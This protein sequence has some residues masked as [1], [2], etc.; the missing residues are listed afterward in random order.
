MA[1]EQQEAELTINEAELT[2]GQVRKLYAL[3]KSIGDDLA[4]EVF[5]KWLPRQAPETSKEQ[6]DPIAAEA[7]KKIACPEWTEY[8]KKNGLDPL[9]IQT[10][11]IRR[12]TEFET[13]P[14]FDPSD[15]N[16]INVLE[17]RSAWNTHAE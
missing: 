9:G 5:E 12:R 15:S 8:S 7:A 16:D 10:S 13:E 4:E 1:H 2:K 11:A 3:R 6:Q 14:N 17:C